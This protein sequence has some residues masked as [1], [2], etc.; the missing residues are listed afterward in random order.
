LPKKVSHYLVGAHLKI[1]V[2]EVFGQLALLV[3]L[4]DGVNFFSIDLLL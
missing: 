1:T 4:F 3:M 2:S